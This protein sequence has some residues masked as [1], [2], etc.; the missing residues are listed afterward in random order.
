MKGYLITQT[1]MYSS[2]ES[3]IVN[4]Q[5]C[6]YPYNAIQTFWE[7]VRGV[8]YSINP[9]AAQDDREYIRTCQNCTIDYHRNKDN[10][11][12]HLVMIEDRRIRQFFEIKEIQIPETKDRDCNKL[13]NNTVKPKNPSINYDI[14]VDLAKRIDEEFMKKMQH[15]L[16]QPY[17]N[18]LP[19]ELRYK[20]PFNYDNRKT[21]V[22]NES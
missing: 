13:T 8:V 19:Q 15:T 11:V 4:A 3:H 20:P 17:I 5:V 12:R 14:E 9:A 22:L 7:F 10:V 6:L 21:E 1:E 2:E 18:D 16:G